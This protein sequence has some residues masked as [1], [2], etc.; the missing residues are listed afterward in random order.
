MHKCIKSSRVVAGQFPLAAPNPRQTD[1]G[2][3]RPSSK[4][5]TRP[6]SILQILPHPLFK[7]AQTRHN[8]RPAR[9]KPF[10]GADRECPRSDPGGR[11]RSSTV[12][13]PRHLPNL[14]SSLGRLHQHATIMAPPRG[15]RHLRRSCDRAVS[16]R[17]HA[18]R[19][20]R[21]RRP[22]HA[23]LLRAGR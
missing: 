15:P 20:R 7:H 5:P 17:R 8:F 22:Q 3:F 23:L 21:L 12:P 9:A 18:N 11:P 13:L 10:Q 14:T 1:L 2:C 19:P 4:L 16:V 6:F